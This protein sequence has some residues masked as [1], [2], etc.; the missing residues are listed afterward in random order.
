LGGDKEMFQI[1]RLGCGTGIF[2]VDVKIGQKHGAFTD[3]G[4]VFFQRLLDR[5]GPT[6]ATAK[7]TLSNSRKTAI[8]V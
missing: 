1:Q 5:P 7:K 4:Y 2:R 3:T 6:T 8:Y